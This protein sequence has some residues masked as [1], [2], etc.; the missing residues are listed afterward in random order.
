MDEN[1]QAGALYSGT[2]ADAAKD[3]TAD[4]AGGFE[5]DLSASEAPARTTMC[6]TVLV[7]P[8]DADRG[9]YAQLVAGP[10]EPHV[11]RHLDPGDLSQ[12]APVVTFA[13]T[14]VLAGETPA[15]EVPAATWPVSSCARLVVADSGRLAEESPTEMP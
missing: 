12:T 6:G 13:L 3:G 11:I 5:P 14:A 7:G 4:M 1:T 15:P 2:E 8:R 9:D 10:P